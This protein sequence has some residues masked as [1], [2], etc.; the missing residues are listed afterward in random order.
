MQA[1]IESIM[2]TLGAFLP[3]LVWAAIILVVGWLIALTVST[4]IRKILE[5]TTID[6]KL[7]S[8]AG[9]EPG[10]GNAIET[11]ISRATYYLIML[12]VLIMVFDALNFTVITDPLNNLLDDLL[13][14]IPNLVAGG[15]LA[16]LAWLVASLL[17][18]IISKGL[19]AL[20]LDKRLGNQAGIDLDAQP[21]P[22]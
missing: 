14:F 1:F 2:V 11:V 13:G 10:T 21:T 4:A 18:F 3:Q 8:N 7:A 12:V 16:V 15:V 22:R 19:G 17:R 20:G 9:L 5:K 6:D